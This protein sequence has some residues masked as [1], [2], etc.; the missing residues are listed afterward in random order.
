MDLQDA[1]VMETSEDGDGAVT[2]AID[3]EIDFGN[4]A[5]LRARLSE[6]IQSGSG[7]LTVE[8]AEVDFVDSTTIGVLIQAKKRLEQDGRRLRLVD[9]QPGVRR[10]FEMSGLVEYLGL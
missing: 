5:A 4:V 6:L 8:L 7:T 1:L 9:C 3:G 2:L 10:V